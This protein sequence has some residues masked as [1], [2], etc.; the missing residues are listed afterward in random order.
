MVHIS[1]FGQCLAMSDNGFNAITICKARCDL[2]G[3]IL[4]NNGTQLINV[5]LIV[6]LHKE[7]TETLSLTKKTFKS[8]DTKSVTN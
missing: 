8:T 6:Q 4:S 1:C 7:G 2:N 5:V 3:P